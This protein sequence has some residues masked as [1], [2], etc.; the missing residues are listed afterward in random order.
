MPTREIN[1]LLDGLL[2]WA[3]SFSVRRIYV[4]AGS[5][6]LA[7]GVAVWGA[8]TA[9]G[10]AMARQVVIDLA[11]PVTDSL[12]VR[13]GVHDTLISE[14][15]RMVQEQGQVQETQGTI[16]EKALA[17]QRLADPK[18]DS[19]L[20]RMTEDTDARRRRDDENRTLMKKLAE[21]GRGS[22]T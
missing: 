11:S 19:A 9:Y 17:A 3:L 20:R 2:T 4:V 7:V 22:G 15:K 14:L 8:A 1:P 13:L 21:T 18:F 12:G 10:R 5:F 16:Q 6:L